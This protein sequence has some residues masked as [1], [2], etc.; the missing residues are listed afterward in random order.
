MIGFEGSSFHG[1]PSTVVA[2]NLFP[3]GGS[4]SRVQVGATLTSPRYA[5]LAAYTTAFP[6]K[7]SGC[8]EGN[9]AFTNAAGRIFSILSSSAAIDRG[10][11][12]PVYSSLSSRFGRSFTYDR[13]GNPR[14]QGN[15]WDIGA[16]ESGSSASV[17]PPPSDSTY[18]TVSV[19]AP[20][21]GST[22]STTVNL[23]ANASDNVAIAGVQFRVDG[24]NSG[25]ED[26]S[27]PYSV[28]LNPVSLSN[29]IHSI[30]AV[31]R[32]TSGNQTTSGAVSV[33]V[34]N[35]VAQDTTDPVVSITAPA[36]GSTIS[37]SAILT[38]NAT[39]NVA[40]AGVQFHVDGVNRGSE[41]LAAPYSYSLDTST[42]SNGSHTVSA[43]ARDA[44]G[45]STTAL[46]V[47]VTV[48]NI[49]ALPAPV[50]SGI[51]L[52]AV[53]QNSAVISFTTNLVT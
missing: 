10:L 46:P 43:I 5:S 2:N 27:A 49:V 33:T 38:A 48:S 1:L 53:T 17:P 31:A 8:L 29:G 21:A 26:T 28:P 30:T 4:S 37:G 35:V 6:S 52:G 24:I 3:A 32:D 50:I 19:T 12:S 14:P 9:A 44:A 34:S 23:T 16:Y 41:D 47:T 40:V 51:A 22:I 45:N 25:A 15:N 7:C 42:L 11:I 18:P 36:A 20:I 39:D 13:A